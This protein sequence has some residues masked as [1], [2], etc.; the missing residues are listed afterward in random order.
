L[1]ILSY[2]RAVEF[3]AV[4]FVAKYPQAHIVQPEDALQLGIVETCAVR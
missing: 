2:Q 3:D 4:T 1:Q